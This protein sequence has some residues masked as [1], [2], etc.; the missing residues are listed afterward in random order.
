M[1][2]KSIRN[3]S[4]QT[5]IFVKKQLKRKRDL[6]NEENEVE[7]KRK[8]IN[9]INF[10]LKTEKM[11]PKPITV[12]FK[13]ENETI[14]LND[15]EIKE[16]DNNEVIEE[17]IELY[18]DEELKENNNELIQ[19]NIELNNNENTKENNENQDELLFSKENN[20]F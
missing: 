20:L 18:N 12:S 14:D 15:K 9:I 13:K 1:L 8:K 19:E 17:V 4:N 2:L 3:Y 16:N 5:N 11:F 10:N 7:N 6:N